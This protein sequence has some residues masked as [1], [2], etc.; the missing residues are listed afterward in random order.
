MSVSLSDWFKIMTPLQA[1]VAELG[2]CP[3]CHTKTLVEKHNDG[4]HIKWDQCRA[5]LNIYA[6]PPRRLIG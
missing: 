5:C 4:E 1:Q 6:G 2:V 3:K